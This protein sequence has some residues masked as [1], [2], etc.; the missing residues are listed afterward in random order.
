[1]KMTPK[2]EAFVSHFGEMG[3]RWGMTR[4]VGQIYA[5]LMI[6]ETPLNADDI[7][8]GLSISR[9]NA[10]MGLKELQSWRLIKPVHFPGDRKEYYETPDDTW[11]V[12]RIIFEERRKRELEPTLTMLRG[13]MMNNPSS[14]QGE[15]AHKKM[16]EIHDMI[17]SMTGWANELQK[18]SND[19]LKKMMKLG[20]GFTKLL[21]LK[22]KII[23]K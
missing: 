14:E 19:D 15:Y 10:S 23:K 13:E 20:S 12:G 5:L 22:S 2:I 6:T 4:T 3:S 8:E 1:M 17:D 9:S 7:V 16:L 11:E 18:L 21:G